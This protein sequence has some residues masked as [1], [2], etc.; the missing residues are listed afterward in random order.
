MD[1]D[2]D[3][4][5]SIK[6]KTDFIMENLIFLLLI[7]IDL[8]GKKQTKTFLSSS[9]SQDQFHAF[10][11]SSRWLKM[12]VVSPQELLSAHPSSHFS[13]ATMWVLPT[14]CSPWAAPVWILKSYCLGL[15]SDV[16]YMNINLFAVKYARE[17]KK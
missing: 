11:P 5:I 9:F 14:S 4:E 1:Q 8:D 10:I 12:V 15:P 6:G 16:N 3:L 17:R 13:P 2:E 7:T